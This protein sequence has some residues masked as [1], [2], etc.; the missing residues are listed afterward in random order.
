MVGFECIVPRKPYELH[1]EYQSAFRPKLS[2]QECIAELTLQENYC[3][4]KG[5]F[6]LFNKLLLFLM[7]EISDNEIF[8]CQ[9]GNFI[10]SIF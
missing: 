6:A 9:N 10:R 4:K 2:Y 3:A 8:W 1:W 5:V 7:K